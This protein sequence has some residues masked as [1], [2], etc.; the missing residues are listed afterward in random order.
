MPGAVS[1][2]TPY[3]RPRRWAEI[4]RGLVVEIPGDLS[5]RTSW[6]RWVPT[7]RPTLTELG[8]I[9]D[10]PELQPLVQNENVLNVL[11]QIHSDSLTWKWQTTCL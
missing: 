7:Y 2:V 11:Y 10:T 5:A 1:R 6:T 9:L 3:R 8:G 4:L